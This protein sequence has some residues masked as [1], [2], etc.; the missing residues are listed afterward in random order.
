MSAKNLDVKQHDL[1]V[2]ATR[3]RQLVS[4]IPLT[5]YLTL[6]R[7]YLFRST[8]SLE[9]VLLIVIT[10]VGRRVMRFV[11]LLVIVLSS[12]MTHLSLIAQKL[13]DSECLRENRIYILEEVREAW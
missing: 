3:S 6:K 1:P 4:F 10:S 12:M 13:F 11:R 2:C 9:V 7:E 8:C 5:L